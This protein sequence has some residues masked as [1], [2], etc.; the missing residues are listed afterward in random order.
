MDF[1]KIPSLNEALAGPNTS[2]ATGQI[3]LGKGAD[4]DA[5]WSF[6]GIASD[7]SKDVDGDRILRKHLDISYA[8]S[9]G[10]VNYDHSRAPEDQIGFLSSVEILEPERIKSLRDSTG[11]DIPDSA[12]VFVE[13]QFYKHVPRAKDV[14]GIMKSAPAGRG[15]GLSLDGVAARDGGN[16]IVKAFMRGVA[17]TPV[18]AHP[19]TMMALIKSLKEAETESVE[20]AVA[21][22]VSPEVIQAI[23]DGLGRV[24]LKSESPGKEAKRL[25]RDE[26]VL[27]LLKSRPHWSYELANRVVAYTI[28]RQSKET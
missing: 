1:S 9:R 7:E 3:L 26:A 2:L 27:F 10:F 15:L 21:G 14:V 23:V 24:L 5:P 13:G 18:P 11:L 25:S 6:Q 22:Q 8:T 20:A 28:G 16:A 4:E 12:T 19:N 17:V